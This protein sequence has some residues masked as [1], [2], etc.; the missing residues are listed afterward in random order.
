MD[1]AMEAWLI[2]TVERLEDENK[3]LLLRLEA[4][5]KE[6]SGSVKRRDSVEIGTPAKGGAMKIYFDASAP[7]ADNDILVTEAKRVLTQ[8]I[9]PAIGPIVQGG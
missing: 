2:A 7:A 8:A 1:N 5:E 4:A 9:A 6:L 3:Q